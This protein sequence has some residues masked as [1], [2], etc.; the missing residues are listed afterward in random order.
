MWA[1]GGALPH[2]CRSLIGMEK[3]QQLAPS[4]VAQMCMPPCQSCSCGLVQP[5][6]QDNTQ[7]QPSSSS[8]H[9]LCC[10]FEL[11]QGAASSSDEE[12]IA[13]WGR[14]RPRLAQRP[15]ALHKSPSHPPRPAVGAALQDARRVSHVD[16]VDCAASPTLR[17]NLRTGGRS[18]PGIGQ[19]LQ[20]QRE[21]P[22]HGRHA[23]LCHSAAAHEAVTVAT[24]SRGQHDLAEQAPGA[25]HSL[26]NDRQNP[27]GPSRRLGWEPRQPEHTWR[28]SRPT[29]VHAADT[30][31]VQQPVQGG[32]DRQTSPEASTA[33][34]DASPA[35]AAHARHS[36]H[37]G[38]RGSKGGS[39]NRSNGS[40]E[41]E[42]VQPRFTRQH[43]GSTGGILRWPG[44]CND[45]RKRRQNRIRKRPVRYIA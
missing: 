28:R 5:R 23:T 33:V 43:R 13:A 35:K 40:A 37:Q 1:S 26:K 10:S 20:I 30:E 42:D 3:S 8:L 34:S 38:A 25:G 29:S 11:S 41:E 45:A 14:K 44:C 16:A 17:S 7:L 36:K 12:P 18:A 27:N 19:R 31:D 9:H 39:P 24:E 4:P 15:P 21:T 32:S 2:A 22:A 6:P